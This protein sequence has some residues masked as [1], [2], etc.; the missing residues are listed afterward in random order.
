MAEQSSFLK[1]KTSKGTP[2]KCQGCLCKT[3]LM[4]TSILQT[5]EMD[6][7]FMYRHYHLAF[8]SDW[9]DKNLHTKLT[10]AEGGAKGSIRCPLGPELLH[11]DTG[12]KK[13]EPSCPCGCAKGCLTQ[14]WV[15]ALDGQRTTSIFQ[16]RERILQRINF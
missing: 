14:C 11:T 15:L 5:L 2:S 3:H 8:G 1:K 10:A 7:V 12:L 16:N 4:V 13:V 6:L 9:A